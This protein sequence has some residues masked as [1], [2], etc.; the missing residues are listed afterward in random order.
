MMLRRLLALGLL[1]AASGCDR[2]NDATAGQQQVDPTQLTS[3]GEVSLTDGGSMSFNITSE[4]YKQWDQAR[5]AFP[6]SLITRFGQVLQPRAPSERS[7]TS[8]VALLEGHPQARAAIERAGLSVR[9]FVEIT[10]ALEQQMMMASTGT[11]DASVPPADGSYPITMDSGYYPPPTY[12]PPPV[13]PLPQPYPAQP[14]PVQPYTPAQPYTVL[15]PPRDTVRRDT[16]VP[17]PVPL[18]A[19]RPDTVPTRRD[20]APVPAPAPTPAPT[21]RDTLAPKPPPRDTARDTSRVT[22]SPAYSI[23]RG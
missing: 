19:P 17:T 3:A 8:A 13:M 18:P 20:T 11:P 2:G 4:R 16:V 15:P 21:P 14:Y 1:A 12:T 10:V 9:G 23:T 22:P 5:R 6:K 7:I